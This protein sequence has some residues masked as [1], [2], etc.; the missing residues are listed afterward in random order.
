MDAVALFPSMTG[1]RTAQIVRKRITRSPIKLRGFNWKRGVIYIR[2]NRSLTSPL[3]KVVKKFLPIRKTQKGMEPGM[4]SE[5]LKHKVGSEDKQWFFPRK[6]PTEE[7]VKLMVG[8]I[9]E[10]AIRILW[11]NYVYKY[12]QFSWMNKELCL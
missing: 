5:G 11:D 7:E 6:N 12:I 4:A 2:V 1:K 10:I 9:A 8:M 3:S